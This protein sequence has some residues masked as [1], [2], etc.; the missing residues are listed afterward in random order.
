M[1]CAIDDLIYDKIKILHE[2]CALGWFI[3]KHANY[4]S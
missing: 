3:K 4:L 1:K 2:L